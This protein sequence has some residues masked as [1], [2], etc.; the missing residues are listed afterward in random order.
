M[1][2]SSTGH[3]ECSWNNPI[4]KFFVKTRKK[5]CSQSRKDKKKHFYPKKMLKIFLWTHRI[6]CWQRCE[7]NFCQRVKKLFGECQKTIIHIYSLKKLFSEKI[8]SYT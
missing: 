7:K 4:D 6:Q 3:V 5:I 2:K 1:L 8:P